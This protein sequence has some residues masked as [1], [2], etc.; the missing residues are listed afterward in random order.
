VAYDITI[1]V[2]ARLILRLVAVLT[3]RMRHNHR[4]VVRLLPSRAVTKVLWQLVFSICIIA[5]RACPRVEGHELLGSLL[6]FGHVVFILGV[7]IIVI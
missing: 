6:C 7:L 3:A 2:F 4:V 5:V 1:A